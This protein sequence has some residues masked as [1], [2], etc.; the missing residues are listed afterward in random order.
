MPVTDTK[1]PISSTA[2]RITQVTQTEIGGLNHT[3]AIP[4]T[5]TMIAT[6]RQPNEASL[7]HTSQRNRRL[8][9]F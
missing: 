3:M 8:A 6:Q 5:M 9:R 2:R 4:M 1:N 7:A